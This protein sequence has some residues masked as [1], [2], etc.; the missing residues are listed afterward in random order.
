MPYSYQTFTGGA[1]GLNLAVSVP[2]LLRAHVSL[3]ANYDQSSGAYSALLLEGI[4]YDWVN[5]ASITM[6]T[7][8]TGSTITL[9]RNTPTSNLLVDWTDG[10][11]VDMDD[12][13]TADRQNLYVVQ[14]QEDKSLIALANSQ[15]ALTQVGAAL[16]FNPINTVAEIPTTPTNQQRIEIRNSAGIELFSPLTGRPSS[17]VGANDLTVRLVYTTAG[18]TWQWVDYRPVDPDNRYAKI[19]SVDAAQATANAAALDAANA[20]SIANAAAAQSGGSIV[21]ETSKIALGSTVSFTGFPADVYRVTVLLDGVS[22][23][24]SGD[25]LLQIGSGGLAQNNGYTNAQSV[26]YAGGQACVETTPTT[27]GVPIYNTS[28][29]FIVSGKLTFDKISGSNKWQVSGT[30]IIQIVASRALMMTSGTVALS[31]ALDIVCLATTSGT[32]DNGT[33]NLT[34]ETGSTALLPQ[35]G[36][37]YFPQVSLLL[38]MDGSNGSTTFT[39]SSQFTHTVTSLGNT[40]IIQTPHAQ[41]NQAAGDFNFSAPTSAPQVLGVFGPHVNQIGNFGTGDFTIEMTQYS[42]NEDSARALILIGDY[43]EMTGYGTGIYCWLQGSLAVFTAG[44]DYNGS[45]SVFAN[46][47]NHIA[48][49]RHNGILTI[50]VNGQSTFSAPL[51]TDFAPVGP[52]YNRSQA[53][54]TIGDMGFHNSPKSLLDEIRIS[55]IARYTS[56]FTPPTVAFPNSQD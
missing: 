41:S 30:S 1:A 44:N 22:T 53:L 7:T 42:E 31:G 45:A 13:L 51:A 29:S 5:D 36:D 27:S 11:N 37:P 18:N 55:K 10:S 19:T 47:K 9:K 2:F 25:I 17:F 14:E 20:I 49:V 32:F 34:Y 6:L 15:L 50:W 28:A 3:Y 8:T 23:T 26:A 56:S 54:V 46:T 43:T 33:I 38:H 40:S 39:D 12:L 21:L 52:A 35:A 4:N 16:G 48:Y 24:A